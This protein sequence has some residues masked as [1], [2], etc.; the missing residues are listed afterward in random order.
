MGVASYGQCN[1]RQCVQSNPIQP[2]RQSNMCKHPERSSNAP[3]KP[4]KVQ[5]GALKAPK[6]PQRHQEGTPKPLQA[7]PQP[8]RRS[9][10]QP[11]NLPIINTARRPEGVNKTPQRLHRASCRIHR[12]TRRHH[13]GSTWQQGGFKRHHRG[14]KEQHESFTIH[15][16]C[17][18]V[19][20]GGLP[21]PP[22]LP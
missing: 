8:V 2:S 14:S 17:S 5:Q 18:S 6:A 15:H 13:R 16:T 21:F 9:A 10:R 22:L 3:Q 20:N 11:A 1:P 12:A 7:S 4:N 19:Q